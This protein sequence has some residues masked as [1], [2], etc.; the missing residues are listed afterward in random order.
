MTKEDKLDKVIQEFSLLPDDKQD[1][2]LAIAQAL[3][4]AN[5]DREAAQESK[6]QEEKDDD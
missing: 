4:F 5:D 6:N 3:V 2:V 1:Y